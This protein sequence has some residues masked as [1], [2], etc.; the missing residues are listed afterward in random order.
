MAHKIA[1]S[2]GGKCLSNQYINKDSPLSWICANGHSWS[3]SLGR[4]KNFNNWCPQCAKYG[5]KLNLEDM[6]KIA[7]RYGGKCISKEYIKCDHPYDWKCKKGHIWT[8]T[9]GNF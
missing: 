8:A 3:T 7:H 4:V 9:S 6:K 2:K 1:H 5:F